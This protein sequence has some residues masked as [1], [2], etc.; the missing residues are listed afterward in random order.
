VRFWKRQNAPQPRPMTH[1]EQARLAAF[2][3]DLNALQQRYGCHLEA[4]TVIRG[5]QIA[6]DVQAVIDT[7]QS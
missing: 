6:S 7:R 1:D 3:R 4:V 5:A 2:A